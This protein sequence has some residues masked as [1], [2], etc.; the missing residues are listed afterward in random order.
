VH[1][2][3]L[4]D[5]G[6]VSAPVCNDCHGNHGAAPPGGSAIRNVCGQCHTVMADYFDQS[7]HAQI[8]DEEGVP[9]CVAC[10]GQHDIERTSDEFLSERSVDFCQNCHQA[11]DTLG[12]E[13]SHMSRALDS[14]S[15][16]T[17][18]GRLTLEEAENL[19]ME[20]SQAFFEL[21]DVTNARTRARSAIHT[22]HR[23]PVEQE[24]AAGL[25][26]ARRAEE[27]GH[28]A[29]AEHRYRRVGLG[30]FAGV[31][32]LLITGLLLKIRELERLEPTPEGG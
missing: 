4:F 10:H 29:L 3:L 19:G 12:L 26:I 20:V 30:V 5:E 7:G 31:V 25:E 15:A 6:D 9:D 21:E 8:F 17:D 18:L 14:L 23:G 2:R 24:V 27:Q 22:F 32:V 11:P 16:A 28:A 13:F 1:G